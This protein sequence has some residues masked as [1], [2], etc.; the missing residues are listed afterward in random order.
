MRRDRRPQRVRDELLDRRLR[1]REPDHRGGLHDRPFLSRQVVEA[2][3]EQ[4]LDRGWH[5]GCREVARCSPGVLVLVDEALLHEH[6]DELRHEQ[7]VALGRG[8]DPRRDLG[9]DGAVEQHLDEPLG[10]GRLERR[11]RDDRDALARRPRRPLLGEDE[12]AGPDD[13]HGGLWRGRVEEVVEQV[14]ECLLRVV[15]VLDEQDDRP[16]RRQG[17]EELAGA[18]EQLGDGESGGRQAGDARQPVTDLGGAM[19][20]PRS[21]RRSSR[22]PRRASRRRRWRRRRAAPRR[23]ART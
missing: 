21:P 18:P 22:S 5:R 19:A 15:D 16:L 3:G 11:H 7:R 20:R 13:E 23:A 9:L 14:E 2:G 12:P 10:L 4:R 1:E 6:R 17:L 8:D